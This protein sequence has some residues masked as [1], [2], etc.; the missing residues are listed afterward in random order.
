MLHPEK[1]LAVSV[2]GLK[3]VQMFRY[4]QGAFHKQDTIQD[5]ACRFA[6]NTSA[7]QENQYLLPAADPK[8]CGITQDPLSYYDDK[9]HSNEPLSCSAAECVVKSDR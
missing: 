4:T 2:A 3:D 9:D 6:R 8:S 7:N 5:V 1:Q